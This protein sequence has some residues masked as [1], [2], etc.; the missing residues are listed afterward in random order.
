MGTLIDPRG[1]RLAAGRYAVWSPPGRGGMGLVW[2][3]RDKLLHRDGRVALTDFD[4]A[5]TVDDQV[6]VALRA[7]AAAAPEAGHRRTP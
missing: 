5:C 6:R 4:V 1:G 7:I 2:L 3:A